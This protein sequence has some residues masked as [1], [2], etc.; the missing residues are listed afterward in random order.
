MRRAP[1][2]ADRHGARYWWGVASQH[3][4]WVEA[5]PPPDVAT[6]AAALPASEA[7]GAGAAEPQPPQQHAEK[8]RRSPA[9]QQQPPHLLEQAQRLQQQHELQQRQQLEQ[10]LRL[11]HELALLQQQGQFGGQPQQQQLP[12]QQHL[13]QLQQ[14]LQFPTSSFQP[15]G[16]HGSPQRQNG[17]D[18][19]RT[20]GALSLQHDAL[21]QANGGAG[22][23]HGGA[24]FQNGSF[25]IGGNGALTLD[26]A[27]QQRL[28]QLQSTQLLPGV[29][30]WNA[31]PG[32]DGLGGG[33]SSA[34]NGGA[35]PGVAIGG[36]GSPSPTAR[37]GG[38]S[39]HA[40][41]GP[42]GFAVA[43]FATAE[44]SGRYGGA[45]GGAFAGL[46]QPAAGVPEQPETFGATSWPLRDPPPRWG[47]LADPGVLE[48][49][50]DRLDERGE[51]DAA[52]LATLQ[53]QCVFYIVDLFLHHLLICFDN[54][55]MFVCHACAWGQDAGHYMKQAMSDPSSIKLG[56][57]TAGGRFPGT[58]LLVTGSRLG[59]SLL[60]SWQ[61]AAA[62]EIAAAAALRRAQT[63]R[64]CGVC[65]QQHLV[66]IGLPSA[67]T[68][69]CDS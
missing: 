53:K 41:H 38:R 35:P 21:Q 69:G 16:F 58:L 59:T 57:L 68:R 18:G 34:F 48:A 66:T 61:A 15:G 62:A 10:Q 67:G 54:R 52:L 14:Q 56:Q 32:G 49:I 47:L 31:D 37:A 60:P 6:V 2:G 28:Q 63:R 23:Q 1:L 4:V 27:Q 36:F 29:G 51:R 11:Q 65:A 55:L 42:G 3:V 40:S 20:H 13:A 12:Y 24:A 46:R 17:H 39:D 25:H 50:M 45:G 9:P 19:F 33:A 44:A 22:G 30:G 64:S 8:E 43:D 7:A 5:P 26:A